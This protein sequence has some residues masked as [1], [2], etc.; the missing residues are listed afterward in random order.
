MHDSSEQIKRAAELISSADAIL[1]GAGAGIGVDSGLPDFRGDEGFWVAYPALHGIPFSSMANPRWFESDPSRA[2]GFYGHRL[3]LYRMTIPHHGFTI[4][5][6][7]CANSR[8][9]VYTSNVDGQFQKAGFSEEQIVECHGSIHWLQSLEVDDLNDIWSAKNIKI[10]VDMDTLRAKGDLPVNPKNGRVVRPN[11]LM[12]G[13]WGWLSHRTDRQYERFRSWLSGR[14]ASGLV[15]V[16]IGAGKAVPSVRN[17]CES[18]V[19]QGAGLVRINPRDSDGPP[20]T[21]SIP[22]GG[23]EGLSRIDQHI[24]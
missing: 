8:G 21:I 2:W 23:L 22:L 5:Q 3:N 9:F 20:G 6:R 17:T 7:W 24:G 4:L 18:L 14:S 15:V 11:I 13:D 1:I 10:Q 16:E 12:F 19:R